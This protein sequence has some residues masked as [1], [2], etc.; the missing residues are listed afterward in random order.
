MNEVLIKELIKLKLNAAN[1]V[2]NNL[3]PKMSEEIK[4]FGRIVLEGVTES[5]NEIKAQPAS[6]PKHPGKLE[7]VTIE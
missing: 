5:C 7:N 1:K 6:K 3:P 4:D 2:V